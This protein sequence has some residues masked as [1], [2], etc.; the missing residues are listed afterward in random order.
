MPELPEVETVKN[1]LRQLII[2]QKIA[3]V[4]VYYDKMIKDIDVNEF[5]K[6]LVGEVFTDILRVG[7]YLLFIMD[8]VIMISHLRME[9]KYFLKAKEE[10]GK[11]DHVIFNLTDGT[12]LR[13]NDTRKFGVIHLFKMSTIEE[14]KKTAPL[15][16]L[17]I[18]P[19]EEGFTLEYLKNKFKKSSRPI[20]TVLLD[21]SIIS[22]LGNIYADE[23]CFMSGLN[24]LEKAK[25]LEIED[26][27][28]IISSSK[29]VLEKAIS[30]G[31][32]TIRSFTS[33]HEINGRFQNELLVHTKKECPKCH[34]KIEKIFVG[35]RGTY[36]CPL[37]QR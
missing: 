11:H 35:K 34:T 17:G 32:T 19:F 20:K 21:Q 2:G 14:L 3:S 29:I 22:G 5:K 13:Y 1:S 16:K 37:C 33:S 31:G 26:L 25:D 23:V 36:Y 4:D 8:H 15:S 12:T 30:L 18:E 27:E 10:K 7:K 28:K 9:G 24:P 6:D